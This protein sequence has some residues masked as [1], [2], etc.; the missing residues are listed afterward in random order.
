MKITLFLPV[1]IHECFRFHLLLRSVLEF[2]L[3]LFSNPVSGEAMT[4][5]VRLIVMH[6]SR[7]DPTPAF[8]LPR[9][10]VVPFE[11]FFVL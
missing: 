6:G 11:S 8:F 7:Q 4:H 5:P 10:A 1:E 9:R 2:L 3:E